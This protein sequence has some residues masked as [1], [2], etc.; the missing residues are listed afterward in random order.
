MKKSRYIFSLVLAFALMHLVAAAQE[1]HRGGRRFSPEEFVQKCDCFITTQAKLTPQEAQNFLPLYHAMKDAQRKL[2]HEKGRLAREAQK[3]E[4]DDKQ[5]LKTLDKFMALDRQIIDIEQDYRKKILKVIPPSKYL[6][7][8]IAEKKFE[9][10]VLHKM[11]PRSH[12]K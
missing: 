4:P 10:D 7:V 1:H 6:K 3:T 8:K 12:R 9:R 2:M 5:S 11:A